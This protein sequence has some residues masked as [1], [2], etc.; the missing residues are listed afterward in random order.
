MTHAEALAALQAIPEQHR[1]ADGRRL[2]LAWY[3]RAIDHAET[4][5]QYAGPDAD[6][7]RSLLT[8]LRAAR[9]GR[10]ARTVEVI[11]EKIGAAWDAAQAAAR[12]AA[13]AAAW[14][15]AWDAARDTAR[16]AAR[17]TAWAAAWAAAWDTAR[18]AAWDTA[19]AAAWDTAW[20]KIAAMLNT[21][22][23][24]GA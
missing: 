6:R 20:D 10:Q 19:W 18:A 16:D 11:R 5:I 24:A 2:Y 1:A 17:D 15:A 9:E 4:C 3:L 22:L 14:D 21:V 12:A 7:M 13:W 8:E 23:Q